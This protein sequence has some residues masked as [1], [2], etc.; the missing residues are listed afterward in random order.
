MRYWA[1]AGILLIAFVLQTTLAH[2]M[3]ISGVAPD[4]L[5]C[6]V[7][8][9]GLLFGW[10]VGAI[11]G[12]VAGLLFDL[13]WMRYI[14]LHALALGVVGMVAGLSERHVFKENL[15]LPVLAGAVGNLIAKSI[16]LLLLLAFAKPIWVVYQQSLLISTVYN[17]VL[18]LIIYRWIY[19]RYEYLRPSVRTNSLPHERS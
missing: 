5:L 16:G 13:Q 9:F 10:E 18:C 2:A 6:V 1:L 8:S 12:A 19:R 15:L 14:G 3:G 7:V 11:S 17:A 4:L